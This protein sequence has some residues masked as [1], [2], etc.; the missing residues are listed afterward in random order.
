M[1]D[2]IDELMQK[3]YKR[4]EDGRITE[5]RAIR[6]IEEY[7]AR[8]V[9]NPTIDGLTILKCLCLSGDDMPVDVDSAAEFQK[10]YRSWGVIYNRGMGSYDTVM[11]HTMHLDDLIWEV[12]KDE[13]YR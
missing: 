3:Y 12:L 4:K 10:A 7:H 8:L 9:E 1:K 11:W 2:L 13:G 5:E 6:I